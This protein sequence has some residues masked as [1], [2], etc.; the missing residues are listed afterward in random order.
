M[1]T[2]SVKGVPE[3]VASFDAA[4]V[5]AAEQAG[6]VI[7]RGALNV[8][9]AMV[10]DARA[11]AHFKGFAPAISYD[12]KNGGLSAEIGPRRGN[13]GSLANIAYFGTSRGG[14]TVRDP[15]EALMDEEPNI[16]RELGK[17]TER[18]LR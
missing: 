10:A 3:L 2:I 6:K 11:S 9:R 13:P 5:E 18:I 7:R 12:T 16:L 14:G 8:K 17:I 4:S 15:V 1:I